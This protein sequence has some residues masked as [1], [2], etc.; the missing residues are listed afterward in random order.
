MGFTVFHADRSP[1]EFGN[2]DE[3]TFLPDGLL[4]IKPFAKDAPTKVYSATGWQ[5]LE[6]DDGHEPSR[7]QSGIIIRWLSR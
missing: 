5:Y 1:D 2:G 3:Y 6:A 4:K 7:R